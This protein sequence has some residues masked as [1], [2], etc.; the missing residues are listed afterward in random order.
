MPTYCGSMKHKKRPVRGAKGT[1]CPEWTHRTT[2]HNLGDDPTTHPWEQTNAAV[3]FERAILDQATG[4]RFA[5]DRRSQNERRIAFEAKDSNDGTWHGYPIPWEDVPWPIKSRWLAE[6]EVT[7]RDL[8]PR[9]DR[10][11][12]EWALQTDEP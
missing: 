6:G 3:L 7:K 8:K 10:A 4:R 11:D 9:Y 5:T 1:R 2:T 12:I